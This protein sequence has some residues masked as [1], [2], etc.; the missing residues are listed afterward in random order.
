MCLHGKTTAKKALRVLFHEWLTDEE[1]EMAHKMGED[2]IIT[3][4]TAMT[5]IRRLEEIIRVS[6]DRWE[7]E[8]RG[9][10]C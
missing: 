4:Q 6:H 5:E 1:I 7:S 8:R 2:P 3:E 10:A 9:I